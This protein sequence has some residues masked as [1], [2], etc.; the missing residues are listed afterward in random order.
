MLLEKSAALDVQMFRL[1][2]ATGCGKMLHGGPQF[3]GLMLQ[4]CYSPRCALRPAACVCVWR[5]PQRAAHRCLQDEE[6][7]GEADSLDF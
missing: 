1:E 4:K 2:K 7:G 3:L 6:P 5:P